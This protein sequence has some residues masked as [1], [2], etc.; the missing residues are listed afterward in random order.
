MYISVKTAQVVN[1]HA[2]ENAYEGVCRLCP[3]RFSRLCDLQDHIRVHTKEKPHLRRLVFRRRS[4]MLRHRQLHAA[5]SAPYACPECKKCLARKSNLRTHR[6]FVAQEKLQTHRR[7]R[8]EGKFRCIYCPFTSYRRSVQDHM[9]THTN[10]KP[11][12]CDVCRLAFRRRCDMLRHRNLHAAVAKPYECP[13]CK[14]CFARKMNL[15]YHRMRMHSDTNKQKK[16]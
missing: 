1:H 13:E 6:D 15:G 11:F 8:V 7:E 10:E 12:E 2:R 16:S 3:A 5:N 9:R 14:K 4:D